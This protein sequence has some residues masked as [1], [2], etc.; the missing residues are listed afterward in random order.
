MKKYRIYSKNELMNIAMEAQLND[1]YSL[2]NGNSLDIYN[3]IHEND[4]VYEKDIE[5]KDLLFTEIYY[6]CRYLYEIQTMCDIAPDIECYLPKVLNYFITILDEDY[7]EEID[8]E[9]MINL[10][11]ELEQ[12]FGFKRVGSFISSVIQ[13]GTLKG[14]EEVC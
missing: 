7:G 10:D 2:Q 4:T 14:N 9:Q 11:R 5:L 8:D 12:E 13:H 3:F 6:L 1:V